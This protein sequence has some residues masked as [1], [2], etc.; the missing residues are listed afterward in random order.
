[1]LCF[2]I[3]PSIRPG[4][5]KSSQGILGKWG[6]ARVVLMILFLLW[7]TKKTFTF[8]LKIHLVVGSYSGVSFPT[9]M[10]FMKLEILCTV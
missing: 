8:A 10:A 7:L 9:H 2:E 3:N 1:M 4:V 5:N 6:F